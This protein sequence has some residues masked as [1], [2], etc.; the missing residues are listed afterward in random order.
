[1]YELLDFRVS[2]FINS[3]LSPEYLS[4][5]K[6][7]FLIASFNYFSV[8]FRKFKITALNVQK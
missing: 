7:L 4:A 2:V 5:L 1:M 3:R 6:K 8:H